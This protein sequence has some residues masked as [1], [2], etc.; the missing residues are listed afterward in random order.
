MTGLI[1][2]LVGGWLLKM[3]VERIYLPESFAVV[4]EGID[5]VLTLF[6]LSHLVTFSIGALTT[7]LVLFLVMK[8]SKNKQ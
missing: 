7:Y 3:E 4:G 5:R 8:K 2:S 1:I 6:L